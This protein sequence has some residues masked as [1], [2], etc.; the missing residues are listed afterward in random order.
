M[1]KTELAQA[2][3]DISHITGEFKLR[4]GQISNEYFDKYRFESQPDL[5]NEI[6]EHMKLLIPK[7]TEVLGALEMGG[8]PVATAL[9]LHTGI[10]V[11]FIRKEPKQYGTC[12]F[13][14]GLDVKGKQICLIED[15][16]TTGGA[17][18]DATKMLREIEAKV[19][20]VL[21][22]IYRGKGPAQALTDINLD[23]TALFTADELR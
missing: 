20:H 3:F 14:E 15:V 9:S 4:S 19:D 23:Y 8:I 17:V 18:I 7:G 13:A 12:Q 5:L 11:V 21:C 2:I 1:K 6:A 16:I 22:V 10:P